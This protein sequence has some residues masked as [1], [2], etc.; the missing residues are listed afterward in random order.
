MD[1]FDILLEKKT[2]YTI[3]QK[4][5]LWLRRRPWLR[6]RLRLRLVLSAGLGSVPIR[7][8]PYPPK[9]P[10]IRQKKK[11]QDKD[12]DRNKCKEKMKDKN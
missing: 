8:T 6:R 12:K 11:N 9:S 7:Q 10:D 4:G 5:R 2:S 1:P 3:R